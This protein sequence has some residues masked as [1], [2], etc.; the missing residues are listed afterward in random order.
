MVLCALAVGLAACGDNIKSGGDIDASDTDA[1]VDAPIDAPVC[2]VRGAGEVGGTCTTDAECDSSQGAFD[3]ICLNGL[4]PGVSWPGQGYCINKYAACV[5]DS[6]CGAGNVCVDLEGDRACMQ[7]CAA[8]PC[9]C[10]N[11]MICT[12]NLSGS[13]LG[14]NACVP[15]NAAAID[16]DACQTFGDCDEGSIC[17]DDGFEFPG[18]QC[19]Q[20]GCTIGNDATCTAG[21]DGH[22]ID[23]GFV[24]AGT[25]C[26]DACVD[27][28]DCRTN[29]GYV[30]FDSG[31][32][33]G[34]YCRHPATG[35]PCAADTD[36]GNPTIWACLTGNSFPGGYCTI[37]AACTPTSGC[38]PGSSLC[39]DPPGPTAPYCVDRCTGAG[40][41][42]CRNGYTCTTMGTAA[43]CL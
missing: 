38:S 35:D 28:N 30:C 39:Y 41:G 20:L 8:A 34:K 25:G 42:T 12:D 17:R 36:C 3:G 22:C 9:A 6:D 18:G 32:A 13:S 26:A 1:A 37:E 7:G 29:D 27:D 16:G 40:Q 31:G 14:K 23:P 21:G 43:G 19:M 5:N 33:D 2:P 24:T 11:G 4:I 10:P 15:G